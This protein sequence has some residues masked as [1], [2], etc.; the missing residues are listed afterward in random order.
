MVNQVVWRLF[1]DEIEKAIADEKISDIKSI[2]ENFHLTAQEAMNALNI[3]PHKQ[4]EYEEKLSYY[5]KRKQV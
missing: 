3:P 2:M 1:G 4:A 5:S